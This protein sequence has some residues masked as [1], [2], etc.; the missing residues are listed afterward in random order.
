MKVRLLRPA[1]INHNA[2][3]IVEVSPEQGNFLLSVGSAEL[4]NN[5]KEPAEE[6]K[7]T[8]KRTKIKNLK[9]LRK[10]LH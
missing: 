1:R 7:D 2:G 9:F 10:S 8:K 5:Q 4:A 6:K 3:D